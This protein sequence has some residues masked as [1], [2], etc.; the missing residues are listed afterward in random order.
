MWNYTYYANQIIFIHKLPRISGM[1]DN[2]EFNMRCTVYQ[3]EKDTYNL[4]QAYNINNDIELNL[5]S[6]NNQFI[7]T[8]NYKYNGVPILFSGYYKYFLIYPKW[9]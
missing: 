8:I 2:R 7:L 3:E 6:D 4:Y 9:R 1:A 5:N